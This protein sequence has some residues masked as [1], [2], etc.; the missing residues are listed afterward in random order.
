MDQASW[1]SS[2]PGASTGCLLQKQAV[3]EPG[4]GAGDGTE[5]CKTQ[6]CPSPSQTQRVLSTLCSNPRLHLG[7]AGMGEQPYWRMGTH[8]MPFPTIAVPGG[9]IKSEETSADLHGAT[10]L[11]LPGAATSTNSSRFT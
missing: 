8:A 7:M 6:R 5:L 10:L 4:A 11:P 2:F 1:E 9:Q 3:A